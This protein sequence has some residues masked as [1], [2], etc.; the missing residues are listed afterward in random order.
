MPRA[1]CRVSARLDSLRACLCPLT[2][3]LGLCSYWTSAGLTLEP[4]SSS[5]W[6]SNAALVCKILS[7]PLPIFGSSSKSYPTSPPPLSITLENLMP[8]CLPRAALV[9]GLQYADRLVR[10]FTALML[11]CALE[12][13]RLLREEAGIVA[14]ELGETHSGRWTTWLRNLERELRKRVPELSSVVQMQQSLASAVPSTSESSATP[15]LSG[16]VL[17]TEVALRCVWLYH[18]ALP[19]AALES[20]FDVGKLLAHPFMRPG[21][22][23]LEAVAQQ[24]AL[25]IVERSP[26]WAWAARAGESRSDGRSLVSPWTAFDLDAPSRRYDLKAPPVEVISAFSSRSTAPPL[27]LVSVQA[28]QVFSQAS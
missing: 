27:L 26:D 25:R 28:V 24:H 4:R 9:R 11:A 3:F 13:A 16:D 8:T 6:L 19:G 18:A 21:A 15:S 7:L 1:C 2:K 22:R 12:R 20:R 17:L 14:K 23:G 10:H 5:K